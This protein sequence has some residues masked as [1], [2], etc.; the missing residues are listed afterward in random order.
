VEQQIAAQLRFFPFLQWSKWL[1][2][3]WNF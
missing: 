3:S 1:E 2:I